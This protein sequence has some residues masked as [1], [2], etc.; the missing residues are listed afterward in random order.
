[1]DLLQE[2]CHKVALA[3]LICVTQPRC[4]S[5]NKTI[6]SQQNCNEEVDIRMHSPGLGQLVDGKSVPSCQQTCCKLIV[7]TCYPQACCKL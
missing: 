3:I 7:K 6:D 2:D 5:S 1:M 4:E